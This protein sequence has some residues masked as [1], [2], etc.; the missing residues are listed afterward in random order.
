MGKRVCVIVKSMFIPI[1]NI[2]SCMISYVMYKN[3]K[4]KMERKMCVS[5]FSYRMFLCAESV[6]FQI[7]IQKLKD[8][9]I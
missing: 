4:I 8:Q 1:Y 3:L 7:A 6:V 5:Q 2:S 9:D